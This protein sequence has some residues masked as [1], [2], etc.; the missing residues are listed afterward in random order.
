MR[1]RFS[2]VILSML[3]WGCEVGHLVRP[4]EPL[5]ASHDALLALEVRTNY[6]VTL[7]FCRDADYGACFSTG[8]LSPDQD[9]LQV[10]A[11]PPGL[12]C[13]MAISVT[14]TGRGVIRHDI[15]ADRAMCFVTQRDTIAYPG[16]L[17]ISAR[18]VQGNWW[19]TVPTWVSREDVGPRV[20]AAYPNLHGHPVDESPPYPYGVDSP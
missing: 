3:A 8:R 9:V 10:Y 11:I 7:S 17:E 1:T 14:P 6:A 5:T 15:P 20:Y 19:H 12:Y 18:S 13:L 4:D 16:E 2:L